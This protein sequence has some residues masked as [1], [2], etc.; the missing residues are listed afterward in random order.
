MRRQGRGIA[1]PWRINDID[2]IVLGKRR[3]DGA[4][5]IDPGPIPRQKHDRCSLALMQVV[6]AKVSSSDIAIKMMGLQIGQV[7]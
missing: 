7:S 6:Q 5:A 4:K 3:N 1:V 2:R